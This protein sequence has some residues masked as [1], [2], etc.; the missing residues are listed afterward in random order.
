DLIERADLV[1]LA[2]APPVRQLLRG[3]LDRFPADLDVHEALPSTLIICRAALVFPMRRPL[4]PTQYCAGP[5]CF[6]KRGASL[7]SLTS[8][9]TLVQDRGITLSKPRRS[10]MRRTLLAA[11]VAV[12]AVVGSAHAANVVDE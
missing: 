3:L 8:H 2:P 1:V 6:S 7:S 11:G 12:L 5:R 9:A 4:L 10:S